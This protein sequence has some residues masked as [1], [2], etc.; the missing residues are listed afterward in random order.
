MKICENCKLEHSGEYGSG[1]F[2]LIR[3]AHFAIQS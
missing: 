2:C 3:D 1:R